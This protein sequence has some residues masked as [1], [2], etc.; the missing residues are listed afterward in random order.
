MEKK[1]GCIKKERIVSA[2]YTFSKSHIDCQLIEKKM[3]VR[4]SSALW[5]ILYPRTKNSNLYQFDHH[6]AGTAATV[7]DTRRTQLTAILL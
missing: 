6:S 3:V 4:S 2:L 7:T 5:Q 1:R